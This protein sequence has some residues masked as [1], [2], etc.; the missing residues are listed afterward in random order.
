MVAVSEYV[1]CKIHMIN[2]FWDKAMFYT[3][4]FC[5]KTTILKL[6]WRRTA[7]IHAQVIQGKF[8]SGI[9]LLGIVWIR[10]ILVSLTRKHRQC[11]PT[12]SLNHYRGHFFNISGKSLWDGGTLT[13]CK[14]VLHLQKRSVLKT[15]SLETNQKS[16]K[17]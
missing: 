17:R 9:Y 10:R 5:I 1:P 7:E 8:T 11:S 2:I 12:S 4:R 3:K 13:S 14:I 6:R 16:S 15:M